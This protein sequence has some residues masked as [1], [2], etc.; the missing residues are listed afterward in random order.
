ML[1]TFQDLLSLKW[2]SGEKDSHFLA[3]LARIPATQPQ[4]CGE[5]FGMLGP[6]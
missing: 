6:L 2:G 4:E 5:N 1:G 3:G